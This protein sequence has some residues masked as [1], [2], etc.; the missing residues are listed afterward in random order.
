MLVIHIYHLTT[1][2]Y[3]F[4]YWELLYIINASLWEKQTYNVRSIFVK[5]RI[6][7]LLQLFRNNAIRPYLS[8]VLEC[9]QISLLKFTIRVELTILEDL[10]IRVISSLAIYFIRRFHAATWFPL[11]IVGQFH[12]WMLRGAQ[13]F[14]LKFNIVRNSVTLKIWSRLLIFL[15][16]FHQ[17]ITHWNKN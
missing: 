7:F 5:S 8:G 13:T 4:I 12:K 17:N 3:N 10:C 16:E 15:P 11:L 2:Q 14:L 9:M 6:N 1:G